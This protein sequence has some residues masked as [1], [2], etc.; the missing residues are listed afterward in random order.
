MING[1]S[2]KE[3][4]KNIGENDFSSKEIISSFFDASKKTKFFLPFNKKVEITRNNFQDS[5]V[6]NHFKNDKKQLNFIVNKN[7]SQKE[8]IFS[9][10]RRILRKTL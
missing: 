10:F 7:I 8:L 9:Y 4:Q 5:Y 1:S 6:N 3:K 2:S